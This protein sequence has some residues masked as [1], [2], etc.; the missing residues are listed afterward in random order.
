MRSWCFCLLA[1][2]VSAPT[3]GQTSPVDSVL[4][5]RDPVP[6]G[7]LLTVP[8]SNNL[9]TVDGLKKVIAIQ[10]PV[11]PADPLPCLLD[12]KCSSNLKD[13]NGKSLFVK[14]ITTKDVGLNGVSVGDF[15]PAR[16]AAANISPPASPPLSVEIVADL[17]T[18]AILDTEKRRKEAIAAPTEGQ[19]QQLAVE[20]LV[21]AFSEAS[22]TCRPLVK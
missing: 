4:K 6:I 20:R 14:P 19:S 7:C 21:V 18:R 9:L 12:P 22:A 17:C 3:F 1:I 10:R 2:V 15:I 16:P 13:G 11:D 8:C 5:P